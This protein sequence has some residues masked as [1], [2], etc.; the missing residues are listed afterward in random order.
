[1]SIIIHGPQ[2]CGKTLNGEK[3][4]RHFGMRQVVDADEIT[5]PGRIYTSLRNPSA[6]ARIK[7]LNAVILTHES[8]PEGVTGVRIVSFADVMKKIHR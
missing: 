6:A 3:L 2:G 7:A 4:R 8:P 1:M 5:S